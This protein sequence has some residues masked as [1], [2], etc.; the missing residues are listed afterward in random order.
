MQLSFS[1]L[2]PLRLFKRKH[3]AVSRSRSEALWSDQPIP[4]KDKMRSPYEF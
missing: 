4:V 3:R 2:A 1:R